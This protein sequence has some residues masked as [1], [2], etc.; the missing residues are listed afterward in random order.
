MTPERAQSPTA[1]VPSIPALVLIKDKPRALSTDVAATFGK[2]HRNVLRDIDALVGQ[3]PSEVCL[4]NFEQ[5]E[6]VRPSPLQGTIKSRAYL[7]TRD[8]FTLLA[9]GFTGKKALTFKL[10]YIAEFNRMEA[11]LRN[12][13]PAPAPALA[14]PTASIRQALLDNSPLGMDGWKR[15]EI[16]KATPAQPPAARP[17]KRPRR[18]SL[19]SSADIYHM[20]CRHAANQILEDLRRNPGKDYATAVLD[21]FEGSSDWSAF[22]GNVPHHGDVLKMVEAAL[23]QGATTIPQRPKRSDDEETF[24]NYQ[25]FLADMQ[26]LQLLADVADIFSRNRRSRHLAGEVESFVDTL[27]GKYCRPA[28]ANPFAS[29][30]LSR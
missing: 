26:P 14:D 5:T 6:D 19:H 4:L 7:M 12:P 24:A 30:A 3:L 25:R 8:G 18:Q 9:F 2:E 20:T 22:H 29:P 1:P 17:A 28:A 10:A 16:V 13:A 15:T 11:A 23:A 27:K 21:Y